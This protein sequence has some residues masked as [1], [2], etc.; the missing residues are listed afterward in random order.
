[1]RLVSSYIRFPENSLVVPTPALAAGL[2]GGLSA[3]DGPR[4]LPLPTRGVGSAAGTNHSEPAGPTSRSSQKMKPE[5]S[6]RLCGGKRNSGGAS[7]FSSSASHGGRRPSKAPSRSAIT[8]SKAARTDVSQEK[9]V[10]EVCTSSP[11]L[12]DASCSETTASDRLSSSEIGSASRATV[13]SSEGLKVEAPSNMTSPESRFSLN[14]DSFSREQ[15]LVLRGRVIANDRSPCASFD[16]ACSPSHTS[17]PAIPTFRHRPGPS[18]K[19]L[20]S[21]SQEGLRTVET[22]AQG[23]PIIS[24]GICTPVRPQNAS[25]F[26]QQHPQASPNHSII[27][28]SHYGKHHSETKPRKHR[29]IR[30]FPS[31][32]KT[33]KILTRLQ[34]GLSPAVMYKYRCAAGLGIQV[35]VNRL[36]TSPVKLSN[37]RVSWQELFCYNPRPYNVTKGFLENYTVIR[38]MM[39]T[40]IHKLTDIVFEDRCT[41]S[42]KEPHIYHAYL[43]PPISPHDWLTAACIQCYTSEDVWL[44]R[45]FWRRAS[46]PNAGV[47]KAEAMQPA[48]PK[49]IPFLPAFSREEQ[50]EQQRQYRLATTAGSFACN[51]GAVCRLYESRPEAA[52]QKLPLH[53]WIFLGGKDMQALD[54]L[55]IAWKL[56]RWASEI[57]PSEFVD[58]SEDIDSA[59]TSESGGTGLL[60]ALD[61]Y[62]LYHQQRRYPTQDQT[63]YAAN[64]A[65]GEVPS[66]AEAE[67]N[68]FSAFGP[69]LYDMNG[70]SKNSRYRTAF[71]M[72]DIPGYGNSTGHPSPCTIRSAA[73]QAVKHA[74]QEL[75]EHHDEDSI[76]VNILGYSL[77][78]AVACALA[79]DLATTFTRDSMF[80]TPSHKKSG[81]TQSWDNI[82]TVDAGLA[83]TMNLQSSSSR[84]QGDSSFDDSMLTF[85]DAFNVTM[86]SKDGVD[87]V[88]KVHGWTPS[89]GY[90]GVRL[91]VNRLILLAPFTS[92][93]AMASKV[94]ASAMGGGSF[95]SR[96]VSGL[97]SKQISW[98]NKEQ[99]ESILMA[100]KH[101]QENTH[102]SAFHNFRIKILHGDKDNVIPWTMG[103]EL[104][105]TVA[106]LKKQLSLK[107]PISF[108][109]LQGE[110][111]A[112]ILSGGSERYVLES[113]FNPY[114][115]HPAAPLALLK[116]YSKETQLPEALP[117]RGIYNSTHSD[118]QEMQVFGP[119]TATTSQHNAAINSSAHQYHSHSVHLQQASGII[120]TIQ[121]PVLSR[122]N[123]FGG[124]L[125]YPQAAPQ[126]LYQRS[127]TLGTIQPSGGT[128]YQQQSANALRYSSSL[129]AGNS[130]LPLASSKFSGSPPFVVPGAEASLVR[131]CAQSVLPHASRHQWSHNLTYHTRNNTTTRLPL[132]IVE[133]KAKYRLARNVRQE[134]LAGWPLNLVCLH[135]SPEAHD[136][137]ERVEIPN[138]RILACAP[139]KI[140]H[141]G[142]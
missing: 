29:D 129:K 130:M 137:Y 1:M 66:E 75:I 38:G 22:A 34:G 23:A 21:S 102:V 142:D 19:S 42:Q 15:T 35:P 71:L 40:Y 33:R 118:V 72:V 116:F 141:A 4:A 53:L 2:C 114:R 31:S 60:S 8:P 43:L 57:P 140:V 100:V 96:A 73:F 52:S 79:A 124:P 126:L 131:H 37:W 64:W 101:L 11:V 14:A 138:T 80:A 90:S 133:N 78:C 99:L 91:A 84:S 48:N 7:P 106:T 127:G 70:V 27:A 56:L 62:R 69:F 134:P 128:P 26:H 121:Q 89:A 13:A 24:T 120:Q 122:A 39:E 58:S 50:A 41:A 65:C 94:A 136:E 55:V 97:V 61:V 105:N 74:I 104:F 108:Q 115:L 112:S 88:C 9:E 49:V 87:H 10:E 119:R 113:C 139:E 44:S 117:F 93:K 107:T 59:S 17:I 18:V 81:S 16:A 54:G 77:G 5:I 135:V 3:V 123:T 86:F 25:A 125:S 132:G 45:G 83:R 68:T 98:D 111:H 6:A 63:T 46:V 20:K 76:I 12:S 67:S 95:L 28:K 82:A 85:R 110:T 36:E 51:P 92:T 47:A 103:F 32:L 30:A 109:R